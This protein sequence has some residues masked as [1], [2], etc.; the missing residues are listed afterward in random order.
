MSEVT[1][2]APGTFCWP[3]LATKDPLAAKA[4]YSALFGWGIKDQD[5]G[6]MGVYTV[7]TLNGKEVAAAHGM[8]PNQSAQGVPPHWFSYIS[9]DNVDAS[10]EEA[11]KLGGNV[12]GGPFDV[13]DNGR[14]G[15]VL[16]ATGAAF[17]IW[18]ANKTIGIQLLDQA[19]TLVWNELLSSNAGA[20]QDFYAKLFGWGIQLHDMG[21]VKYTVYTRGEVPA[22]GMMQ[23][24]A[25]MGPMPSNWLPYFGSD[26]VDATA[27]KTR[28]L[29]GSVMMPPGDVP[30]IGRF[31][32]L[33]D[34]Q[35]AVFG[36]F[37]FLP[38]P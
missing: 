5:M 25:D 18:Q 12:L 37:K 28:E 36:I 3:E 21:P 16:D 6:P 35:G 9:A 26:D 2:H 19:G 22:A 30:N 33:Q 34:P 15:I 29:G 7:F 20:I 31:T 27:A 4:F 13:A 8:D 38:R 17:G 10:L 14:M 24:T 11:K 23:M 1:Q 32:V